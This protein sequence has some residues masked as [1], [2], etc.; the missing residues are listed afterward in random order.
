MFSVREVLH[1][2]K[3]SVFIK[4]GGQRMKG[5][6][7]DVFRSNKSTPMVYK[8]VFCAPK[9]SPNQHIIK[10]VDQRQSLQIV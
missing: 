2:T 4:I 7:K 9:T 10:S 8:H 3:I 1:V 6:L 5:L